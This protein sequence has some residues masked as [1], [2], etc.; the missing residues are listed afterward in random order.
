MRGSRESITSESGA[1]RKGRGFADATNSREARYSG[2]DGFFSRVP[3]DTGHGEGPQQSIEGWI[4]FIRGIHEEAQEEDVRDKFAEYGTVKQ[5]HL[6]VDRRSGFVKG[7]CLIE[8]STYAE[9]N[10]AIQACAGGVLFMEQMITVDWAFRKSPRAGYT[11]TPG[12][13][14]HGQEVDEEGGKRARESA[15]NEA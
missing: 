10:A 5:L 1:T 8:Y 6:N 7:Y 13:Q 9:A 2:K 15:E 12:P 3:G 4:I 11:Y 14:K